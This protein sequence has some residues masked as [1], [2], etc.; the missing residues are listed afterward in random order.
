MSVGK[1]PHAAAVSDH[2]SNHKNG[3]LRLSNFR[4]MSLN[5]PWSSHEES[6]EGQGFTVSLP[7]CYTPQRGHRSSTTP[8]TSSSMLRSRSVMNEESFTPLSSMQ[9]LSTRASTAGFSRDNRSTAQ[10]LQPVHLFHPQLL[11]YPD[12]R[13]LPAD[14]NCLQLVKLQIFSHLVIH[15]SKRLEIY[16]RKLSE[17]KRD[18]LV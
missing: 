18:C 13:K 7:R 3:P 2:M 9:G 8:P 17:H 15:V 1:H 5:D 11:L 6:Q 10:F 16:S 12:Q 14:Q 4:D